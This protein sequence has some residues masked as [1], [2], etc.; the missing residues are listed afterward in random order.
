HWNSLKARLIK[1]PRFP[2]NKLYLGRLCPFSAQ[3]LPF[4]KN[5]AGKTEKRPLMQARLRRYDLLHF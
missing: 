4:N 1:T 5:H 3:K 2:Y